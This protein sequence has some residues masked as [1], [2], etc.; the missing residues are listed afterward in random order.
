MVE[1][2][3]YGDD[4]RTNR[5][6]R[7]APRVTQVVHPTKL[8]RAK[9]VPRAPFSRTSMPCM[10]GATLESV[11]GD[12]FVATVKVKLGPVTQNF[13][14]EATFLS[15]DAATHTAVIKA[16]GQET[17]GGGT[18]LS[19]LR[20]VI[21]FPAPGQSVRSGATSLEAFTAEAAGLSPPDTPRDPAARQFLLR[22]AARLT[23]HARFR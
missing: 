21:V 4:Y 5:C 8:L 16:S 9:T 12:T 20:R 7:P 18:T 13:K 11:D 3:R 17:K 1:K 14:G 6:V 19:R 2:C 10:P 22:A 15:K 23:G